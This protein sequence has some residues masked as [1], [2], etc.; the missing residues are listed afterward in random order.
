MTSLSE[1][2]NDKGGDLSSWTEVDAS[3]KEDPEAAERSATTADAAAESGSKT[4]IV[5]PP[6]FLTKNY[7]ISI[8]S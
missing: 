3:L 2:S 7:I 8:Y 4:I 1:D 6:S 5:S